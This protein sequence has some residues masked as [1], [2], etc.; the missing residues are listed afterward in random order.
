MTGLELS[1]RSIGAEVWG[2]DFSWLSDDLHSRIAVEPANVVVLLAVGLS[3]L[4]TR[5]RDTFRWTPQK[6]ANPFF[7]GSGLLSSQLPLRMCG[8]PAY[9]SVDVPHSNRGNLVIHWGMGFFKRTKPADEPQPM[10]S[11]PNA[12]ETDWMAGH[13]AFAAECDVDVDDPRQIGEF[14]E[15]LLDSWH[16]SP[17][18]SRSDPNASINVL[19]TAFGEYLVRHTPLRW[20]IASDAV[21]TELA[22]HDDRS[23]F[24][25]YPANVVAKRWVNQETGAFIPAMASDIEERLRTP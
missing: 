14:Y 3:W 23:E 12:S 4:S 15:M 5:A 11:A 2:G 13:L 24:L 7:F 9:G 20:V 21:S 19:G 25:I 17:E 16:S 10:F 6:T 18:G 22:V 1:R 8:A